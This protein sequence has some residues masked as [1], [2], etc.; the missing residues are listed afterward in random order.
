MA[1]RPLWPDQLLASAILVFAIE[2]IVRGS[3]SADARFLPAALPPGWT[4][5]ICS[6][7]AD[8]SRRRA[9]PQPPEPDDR[10]AA[11]AGCWPLSATRSRIISA[12]RSIRPISSIPA[13]SVELMPLLVRERPMTAVVIAV[14][15]VGGLSLLVYALALVAPPR[16]DRSAARRSAWRGYAGACRCSPS[17]SRS[18]TT[19][20]SRGRATGCRSSRSCGTRRRTTPPTASPG[21]RAQRADGQGRGAGGLFRQGDRRDRQARVTA[22]VPA[23]K[24]DIIIVMSES[25]WDPTLLPGVTITPDPI[26]NV[27]ALRS[28]SYVLAGI[29]RHDRQ[30]RVRGADRLFQCLPAATAASPTSNM[31]ARR[32]RRWRPS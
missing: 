25:F 14:G 27:R 9:R 1:G 31:C 12:I 8:R 13:R 16:A 7:C 4:T 24:P 2:W 26:P 3:T 23:E 20:P 21:L 17:S 10:G 22:S 19:P 32:C 5:I 6:R 28:G 11:G 30:C 15:I 18:W 29:R